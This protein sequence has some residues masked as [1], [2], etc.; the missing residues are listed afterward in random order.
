MKNKIASFLLK[1]PPLEELTDKL[2]EIVEQYRYNIISEDRAIDI[3]TTKYS[4]VIEAYA[5]KNIELQQII[6][7]KC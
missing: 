2:S 3:L 4:N 7:N 5:K 1:V 6:D